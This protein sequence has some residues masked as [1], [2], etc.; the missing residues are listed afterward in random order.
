MGET[1]LVRRG[2]AVSGGIVIEPGLIVEWYGLSS[3]VPNGWLLC[4]GQNDTPDLRDKFIVGAGA[5]YAIGN[6]G[7]SA[8]AVLITH[9]HADSTTST[10]GSH[11]HGMRTSSDGGVYQG[12]RFGNQT[13]GNS[14]LSNNVHSHTVTISNEGVSATNANL[15]P[16]YGL[17]HIIKVG[18]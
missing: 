10:S 11:I 5:T 4:D 14:A 9:T 2:G 3:A 12:P 7:G 1:L 8:D 16:Y 15:P 17:F 6:T 13:G 18:G